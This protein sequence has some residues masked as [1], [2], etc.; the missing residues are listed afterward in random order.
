MRGTSSSQ[1]EPYL[2]YQHLSSIRTNILNTCSHRLTLIIIL[3][4][5]ERNLILTA[6]P[7]SAVCPWQSAT[8]GWTKPELSKFST[9]V[10]SPAPA[11]SI[12][13][14]DWLSSGP[15]ALNFDLSSR[16][17]A[18][19]SRSSANLPRSCFS[20]CLWSEIMAGVA[21]HTA[22][23]ELES[24]CVLTALAP[25]VLLVVEVLEFFWPFLMAA[26]AACSSRLRKNSV[27]KVTLS[28]ARLRGSR[29]SLYSSLIFWVRSGLGG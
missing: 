17:T 26:A 15:L 25:V 10:T 7:M 19:M 23:L 28:T 21:F 12:N 6:A 1:K 9:L 20:V 5:L 16:I 8:S 14:S 27:S 24:C 11:A 13:S 4:Q 18:S 22:V 3:T 29:A 2:W